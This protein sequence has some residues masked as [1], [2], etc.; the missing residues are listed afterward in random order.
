MG[1]IVA[2]Q[3]KKFLK[4]VHYRYVNFKVVYESKSPKNLPT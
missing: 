4:V 2:Y 3:S 1:L